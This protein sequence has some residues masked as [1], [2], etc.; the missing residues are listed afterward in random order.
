MEDELITNVE[1]LEASESD[2]EA[3]EEILEDGEEIEVNDDELID[4]EVSRDDF[5]TEEDLKEFE[6]NLNG[7]D[8]DYTEIL[9][10][11]NENV[12]SISENLVLVDEKLA[13]LVELGKFNFIFFGI[14]LAA[15][16]VIA[17]GMFIKRF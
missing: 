15:L 4:D 6:L 17:I 12:V 9:S 10:S 5:L 8:V 13:N 1:D 14:F 7:E 2:L 11:I 16:L 3:S